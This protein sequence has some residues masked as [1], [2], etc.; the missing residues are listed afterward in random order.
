MSDWDAL[1]AEIIACRQCPRLVAYREQVAQTK[2]ASYRAWDYWGKPVPNFGEPNG[3]LLIVGLAPA[4]HG[5]NRTGRIFTGDASGDFLFEALHRTGF[6]NQPH[7]THRDDGLTLH[8]AAITAAVHCV[9]PGNKPTPAEQA[10]CFPY[11]VRTYRLMPHLRGFLALGRLAFEACLRLAK[12][13]N[14]L[15]ADVRYAFQ[16]GVIYEL[17]DGKFLAASYHPSARN[18][19]TKLLTMEMMMTLLL[20]V[21]TRLQQA[22]DAPSSA[23]S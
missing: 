1:N 23:N 2:R 6:C 9:P 13:E 5:G 3:K 17:R 19:Y 12:Q 7:S 14:L 15:S 4:A 8:D 10:C 11:L 22:G 21:R 18:T 20:Q 16:H